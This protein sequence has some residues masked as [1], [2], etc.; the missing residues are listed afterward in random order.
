MIP[1]APKSTT[2][3]T[4]PAVRVTNRGRLP[5]LLG[6]DDDV[7][8]RLVICLQSNACRQYLI[9]SEEDFAE[10]RPKGDAG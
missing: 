8:Y 3:L 9:D 2:I 6:D 10:E 4:R 7:Y 5:N 1:L